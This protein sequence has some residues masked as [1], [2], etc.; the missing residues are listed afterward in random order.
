MF[1]VTLPGGD[2]GLMNQEIR[3]LELW[4]RAFVW[5]PNHIGRVVQNE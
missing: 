2:A 1:N 3:G 5:A 4:Q